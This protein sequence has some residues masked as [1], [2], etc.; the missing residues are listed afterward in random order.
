LDS[1]P[2]LATNY[3][4]FGLLIR[5]NL[6]LPGV[7][8]AAPAANSPSLLLHLGM[9]PYSHGEFLPDGEELRYVSPYANEAGEPEMRI[10]RAAK[11]ALLRI[12]YFDG[13]Q[14]WLDRKLE[15]LWATWPAGSS[16]EHALTYLLGPVLGILLRLRGMTCLHAS[17]VAFG[18]YSVAF[19]GSAGAGK[20]TTAAALA[21]QGYGVLSDDIVALAEREGT[22]HVLPSYAHVCLWPDSVKMLYGSSEALPR[23]VPDWEKRRLALGDQGARFEPGSLPLGAIYI[24]ADPFPDSSQFVEK[25]SPQAALISLVTET[26]ANKLLDRK[27]RA[28][29][30]ALLGRLVTSVPVRQVHA[31]RG[32]LQIEDLCNAILEDLRTLGL[33]VR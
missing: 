16:F 8:R 7:V 9:S 22:Y 25:I 6:P 18:G 27:Q 20:S 21:Q 14:F 23:F 12:A 4:L 31:N 17:A 26:F 32:K 2:S 5:S 13:T 19:V 30:F 11:D 33:P 15:N 24:L 28:T 1:I 3:S 10:W 29:E